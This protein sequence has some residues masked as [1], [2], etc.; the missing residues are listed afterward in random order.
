MHNTAGNCRINGCQCPGFDDGTR[1]ATPRSRRVTF[2]VPDG[3][4][5]QV[6]LI[7]VDSVSQQPAEDAATEGG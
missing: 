4:V 7:P 5:L 1:E 3:Y 6:Q 2:E